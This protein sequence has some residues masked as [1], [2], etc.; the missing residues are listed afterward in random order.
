MLCDQL[1]N[2][3]MIIDNHHVLIPQQHDLIELKDGGKLAVQW[4]TPVKG[5]KLQL[6][7]EWWMAFD[8]YKCAVLWVYP[9]H[10]TELD[11]YTYHLQSKFTSSDQHAQVINYNY[12]SAARKFIHE[13]DDLTLANTNKF[14]DIAHSHLSM[15]GATHVAF[16]KTSG[17]SKASSG[18][19]PH[20]TQICGDF[21]SKKGGSCELCRFR[22]TCQGCKGDYPHHQ[23]PQI[24]IRG[25]G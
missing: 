15:E 6:Q 14:S 9:H 13:W 20:G 7:L 25:P 16:N 1:I 3:A 24:T 10:Q 5:R 23:C 8:K 2:F 18:N 21:N 19:K 12:K 11:E 17:K 4:S 22:H